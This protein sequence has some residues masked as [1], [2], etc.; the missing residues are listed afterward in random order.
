MNA[1]EEIRLVLREYLALESEYRPVAEGWSN[2]RL[3]GA[4]RRAWLK[5]AKDR[6]HELRG[7]LVKFASTENVP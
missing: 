4:A 2:L 5:K 7:K 6:L 3:R 1:L